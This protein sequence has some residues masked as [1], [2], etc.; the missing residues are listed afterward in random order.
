MMRRPPRSTL[1]PYTTLFRSVCTVPPAAFPSGDELLIRYWFVHRTPPGVYNC[2]YR[3][4][5][6]RDRAGAA[7]DRPAQPGRAAD[8]PLAAGTDPQRDGVE[9]RGEGLRRDD[10]R[11]HRRAGGRLTRDLLRAVQGQGGLLPRRDGGL[12]GRRDGADPLGL[13]ARQALGDDGPRRRRRLP[14]PAG[15]QPALRPHGAGRGARHRRPR[16][17]ALRLGQA[18]AAVAARQRPRRPGRGGSDPLQRRPRRP[19]RRRVADRRPDPRREHRAPARAA[20]GHRL[21]HDRPLPRP[22][23]GAAPIPRGR[24]APGTTRRLTGLGSAG[25]GEPW[26]PPR[27]RHRL[28][29]EVIARSQRERLLEAAARIVATKG[30]AAATV[31]DLTKEAGVSRTTF[32]ELYEDKEACF[33]AAYDNAVEALVRRVIAAYESEQGWPD[34]AAAGLATRSE[35]HTYEV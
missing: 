26:R 22:G 31:G 7:A 4:T 2:V 1:F 9:L 21:H 34:R 6:R 13:L 5:E 8:R 33:L 18:G 3:G 23:G 19:R 35:E 11:R 27:G 10:D 16:L 25:R 24:E 12:A 17:R 28:P 29:P 32:Y 14:R 20:A 30:Y 15:R